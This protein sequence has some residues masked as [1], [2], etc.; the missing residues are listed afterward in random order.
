[1]KLYISTEEIYIDKINSIYIS[2]D[3]KDSGDISIEKG[4]MILRLCR[5]L[6][7]VIATENLCNIDSVMNSINLV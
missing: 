4:S 1:M 6:N 7:E 3:T 2:F 5:N